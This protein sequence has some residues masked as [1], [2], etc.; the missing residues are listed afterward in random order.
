M[1]Q[2]ATNRLSGGRAQDHEGLVTKY[3]KFARDM[4]G[5]LIAHMFNRAPWEGFP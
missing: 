4:L 3:V 1:V 2:D 5:P